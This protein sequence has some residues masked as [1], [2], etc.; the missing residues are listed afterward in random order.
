MSLFPKKTLS[1]KILF[2]KSTSKTNTKTALHYL[3]NLQGSQFAKILGCLGIYSLILTC[4]I[5]PEWS[6]LLSPT[7]PSGDLAADMLLCNRIRDEGWLL[8]GHYSRWGFHHPGPFWFLYNYSM[9][10]V[11]NWTGLPRFQIWLIGNILIESL[12]V[13]FSTIAISHY[14][15]KKFNFYYAAIAAFIFVHLLRVGDLASGLWMPYR[16][17]APYLALLICFLHIQEGNFKYLAFSVLLSMML[18]HGYATMPFFTIPILITC[19]LIGYFRNKKITN[20]KKNKWQ[21]IFSIAITIAFSAP[22]LIDTFYSHGDG[23]ISKILATQLSFTTMPKAT[24]HE[25]NWFCYDALFFKKTISLIFSITL[26]PIVFVVL[27]IN[28]NL[29]NK[30]LISLGVCF[31]VTLIAI[32]YHK[33]TPSPLYVYLGTFLIV[34]PFLLTATI[35][36]PL[37]SPDC[38]TENNLLTN[39]TIKLLFIFAVVLLICIPLK[40]TDRKETQNVVNPRIK[41]FADQIEANTRGS[42]VSIDCDDVMQWPFIAGLLLELDQRGVHACTTWRH[43]KYIFTDRMVCPADVQANYKIVKPGNHEKKCLIEQDGIGLIQIDHRDTT[44][45][46]P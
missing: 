11:L 37:F 13:L 10:C 24:W 2:M 27:K 46:Q 23:N 36:S 30:I 45:T 25:T 28:R 39:K 34:I 15:L 42:D 7:T 41:A 44:D 3:H 20:I 6:N 17:V 8:V 19:L 18:I 32:I 4:L 16:L 5:S 12:L 22:I 35:I 43:L 38:F 40:I 21:I 9:E 1:K 14:F 31:F 26:L 29:R 33:Q